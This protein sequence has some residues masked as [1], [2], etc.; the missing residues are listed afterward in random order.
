MEAVWNDKI[1][2]EDNETLDVP[3]GKLRAGL[4]SLSLIDIYRPFRSANPDILQAT[5]GSSLLGRLDLRIIAPKQL[6]HFFRH[7]TYPNLTN[8]TVGG[9]R[10]LLPDKC[11]MALG[12]DFNKAAPVKPIRDDAWTL[13]MFLFRHTAILGLLTVV[14]IGV[15]YRWGGI[16]EC[17]Q[18]SFE[19]EQLDRFYNPALMPA[20]SDDQDRPLCG[21]KWKILGWTESCTGDYPQ[22]GFR[23]CCEADNLQP[24][25]M[26]DLEGWYDLGYRTEDGGYE[27]D[28]FDFDFDVYE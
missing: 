20:P 18:A 25:V 13:D 7:V 4:N 1:P 19:R 21:S 23:S 2:I 15:A 6:K 26:H 5:F 17:L 27:E 11:W 24:L 14:R 10:H 9:C 8:L 22:S 12:L 28:A 16:P 3:R